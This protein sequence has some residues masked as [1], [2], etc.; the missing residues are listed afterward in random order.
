MFTHSNACTS[1]SGFVV[2][3]R[4]ASEKDAG[5]FQTALPF[6][7]P[8][9]S[10]AQGLKE[11]R[12]STDSLEGV[13][14]LA[15]IEPAT[16]GSTIRRSNQLSYNG[17]S[18]WPDRLK[19]ILC[20][21]LCRSAKRQYGL[22]KSNSSHLARQK[23]ACANCAPLAIPNRQRKRPAGGGAGLFLVGQR[24]NAGRFARQAEGGGTTRRVFARSPKIGARKIRRP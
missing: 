23:V 8:T 2:F 7:R 19:S 17:T 14:P 4:S 20:D 10:T 1:W 22:M 16:S 21:K 11:F 15:G 18:A 13:V 3:K 9:I 12:V 5:C 24:I 6:F